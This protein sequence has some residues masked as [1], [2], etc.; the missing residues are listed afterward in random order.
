VIDINAKPIELIATEDLRPSDNPDGCMRSLLGK[1]GSS[2]WAEQMD[3]LNNVRVLAI[4]HASATL[5]PQLHAV[6]RAVLVV[7]DNL[8]SNLSKSALM[9]LTDMLKYLKT[10]MDPELDHVVIVC[11]KKCAD[12]A[13]FIA[14]EAKRCMHAM[15]QY[16]TE[17][18]TISALIHANANKN[19][20]IRAK[21]ATFV[22]AVIEAMGSRLSNTREMERLF[23]V[24]VHYLSEGNAEPRAAGKKAILE[25]HEHN[26][27]SGE[28]DRLLRRCADADVRVVEKLLAQEHAFH[29]GSLGVT[30]NSHLRSGGLGS[31]IPRSAGWVSRL[32]FSFCSRALPSFICALLLTNMRVVKTMAVFTSVPVPVPARN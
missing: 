32:L 5:L 8:R 21:V 1:L 10:A 20:L 29:N 18:R 14:D 30:A 13:G 7:V 6:V 12:T 3:A 19:P 15:I 24:V 22:C 2:D 26:R 4:Y 28:F 17:Q 27:N 16:C 25:L 9:S 31:T 11:V 23:P